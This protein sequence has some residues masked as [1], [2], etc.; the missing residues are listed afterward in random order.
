MWAQANLDT[1]LDVPSLAAKAGLL[2][3]TFHR[4]FVAA[5]GT[6]PA[7]YIETVRLDAACILLSQ[8]LPLKEIARRV[9]LAPAARVTRVF[10]RRFGVTVVEDRKLIR[11][12][13]HP[14]RK[15]HFLQ[16]S[17]RQSASFFLCEPV[18]GQG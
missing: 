18:V 16:G 4:P 13:C 3:R 14:I 15:P 11:A 8:K 9:G 5:I 12:M 6:T 7:Q 17:R 10:Q 2:E 1:A